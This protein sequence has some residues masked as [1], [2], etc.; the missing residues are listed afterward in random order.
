MMKSH[1]LFLGCFCLLA[2]CHIGSKN[3][4]EESQGSRDPVEKRAN[5]SEIEAGIKS[6][7]DERVKEGETKKW[8]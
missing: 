7:I 8:F 6:Y 3:E 5:I 1:I 4:K 2:S